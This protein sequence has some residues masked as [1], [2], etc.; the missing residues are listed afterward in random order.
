MG[1]RE[2]PGGPIH[3]PGGLVCL[4]VLFIRIKT[5]SGGGVIYF[6]GRFSPL[7]PLPRYVPETKQFILFN[8][9]LGNF[10]LQCREIETRKY[11]FQ[12]MYFD[13]FNETDVFLSFFFYS[14]S[15]CNSILRART[16]FQEPHNY[17]IIV[18]RVN[19]AAAGLLG[20]LNRLFY[21]SRLRII[22]SP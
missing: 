14:D 11:I 5:N 19:L 8:F 10:F 22:S 16:T 4:S 6:P 2:F 21:H 20:Y 15:F 7:W 1:F 12:V 3:Y 9:A 13:Q 18:H 17:S